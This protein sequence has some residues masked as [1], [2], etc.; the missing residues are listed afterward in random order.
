MRVGNITSSTT[1]QAFI[2]NFCVKTDFFFK[3][4]KIV[5]LKKLICLFIYQS[6]KILCRNS[7]T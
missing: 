6:V 2:I 1:G 7:Y 3:A 4:I 5:I